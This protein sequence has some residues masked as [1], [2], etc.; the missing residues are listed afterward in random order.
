MDLL[1][2]SFTPLDLILLVQEDD[3]RHIRMDQYEVVKQLTLPQAM[4]RF[5]FLLFEI[6]DSFTPYCSCTIL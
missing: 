6:K 3:Q 4:L 2:V 5:V 1:V